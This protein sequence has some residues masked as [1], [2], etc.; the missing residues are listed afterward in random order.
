M[1]FEQ[2]D[3][4]SPKITFYYKGKQRHNSKFGGVLTII[5]L[6]LIFLVVT[7]YMFCVVTYRNR[8]STFYRKYERDVNYYPFNTSGIFHFFQFHKNNDS[9]H[10][11]NI[12]LNSVR[13]IMLNNYEE[14]ETNPTILENLEHWVYGKCNEIKL[15]TLNIDGEKKNEKINNNSSICIKYYYNKKEKTYY[16]SNN[17][18][19]F[20]WPYLQHGTAHDNNILLGTVIEKCNNDSVTNKIFGN[21]KDENEINEYLKQFKYL[22]LKLL[23]NEIDLT[24]LHKPLKSFFYG[25]ESNLNNEN[26]YYSIFNIYFHPLFFKTNL[27]FIYNQYKEINTFSIDESKISLYTHKKSDTILLEY[28]FYM[29]NIKEIYGR[30]YDNILSVF[31]SIG[32]FAQVLYYIFYFLNYFYNRYA[33]LSNTQKLFLGKDGCIEVSEEG[34]NNK[35]HNINKVRNSLFFITKNFKNK[36]ENSK[37]LPSTILESDNVQILRRKSNN[38]SQIKSLDNIKDISNNSFI[39]KTNKNNSIIK[40]NKIKQNLLLARNLKTISEKFKGQTQIVKK[41]NFDFNNNI[42]K[43]IITKK[44]FTPAHLSKFRIFFSSDNTS[45]KSN[46]LKFNSI[47][48]KQKSA[49]FNSD[50][51]S[52]SKKVTLIDLFKNDSHPMLGYFNINIKQ[53]SLPG[54]FEEEVKL[55]NYLYYVFTCKKGNSNIKIFE[56]FHTKLL[57]EEYLYHSHILSYIMY[58][59]LFESQAIINENNISRE[60]S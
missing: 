20:K 56:T 59:K 43:T 44:P 17:T 33:L 31:P 47:S 10:F 41:P 36:K 28:L 22:H 25:I 27:G 21:C 18:N 13:I 30:K 11:F 8:S 32:G 4:L 58:Q 46:K 60:I 24:N 42:S 57:S 54:S 39:N 29:T 49:H 40:N 37:G 35:E 50:I 51:S 12:D 15:E 45:N 1:S 34:D 9:S 7:Y 52:H 55:K 53:N 14:Y 6:F 5:M 23:G 16:Q 19:K 48:C 2:I 26:G 3:F 38:Q